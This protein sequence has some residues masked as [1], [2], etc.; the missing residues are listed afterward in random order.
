MNKNPPK[1]G[2]CRPLITKTVS[3][4]IPAHQS[5]E[6]KPGEIVPNSGIYEVKHDSQHTVSHEVTC[7]KGEP[8]PPCS[9]CGNHPRFTLR[10][11]TIHIREHSFFQK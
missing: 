9:H 1:L 3:L 8:F 11:Q 7:V 4:G 10:R 2:G 5:R 6:Y